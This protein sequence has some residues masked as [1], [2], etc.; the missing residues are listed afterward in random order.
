VDA[1]DEPAYVAA[2]ES[3]G[4]RLRSREP[5]HRYFRPQPGTDRLVQVHVCNAG[6]AWERAHLLFPAYLRAHPAEAAAYARLKQVLA[7][8]FRDDRIGY[9]QAKGPFIAETLELGARWADEAGWE[10]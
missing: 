4:P 1:E 2:I 3:T 10:P 6:S 7:T 5:G 9:T 8:S